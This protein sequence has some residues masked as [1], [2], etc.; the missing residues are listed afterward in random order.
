[1]KKRQVV[2]GRRLLLL[3]S[4]PQASPLTLLDVRLRGVSS[5]SSV[6]FHCNPREKNGDNFHQIGPKLLYNTYNI[7]IQAMVNVKKNG[8]IVRKI[9]L[10]GFMRTEAG[11]VRVCV[12]GAGEEKRRGAVRGRWLREV[13]CPS[14]ESDERVW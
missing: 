2:G 3:P 1:M 8:V 14:E 13:V 9:G 12:C 11:C 7:F 5:S 6:G 10:G 4:R